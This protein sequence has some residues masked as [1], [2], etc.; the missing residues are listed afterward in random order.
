MRLWDPPSYNSQLSSLQK[1]EKLE[2]GIVPSVGFII[3]NIITIE[4]TL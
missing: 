2:Y 4:E 1:N 3:A